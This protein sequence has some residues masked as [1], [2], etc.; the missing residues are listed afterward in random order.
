MYVVRLNADFTAPELPAVEGKT[1]ARILVREHREAPAPF[2][3]GG[4]Y[5]L[6]TSACTGWTPNAADVAVAT[7]VFGPYASQGNPCVGVN[8]ATTFGAQSAFVLPM[9]GRTNRFIFMADQWNA[10]DLPDSRHVWLPFTVT[11]NGT[12]NWRERW[13]LAD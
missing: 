13:N 4:K 2:K 12:F 11:T 9:P 3:C 8:A 6:I 7:N 5:F 1:W 10:W